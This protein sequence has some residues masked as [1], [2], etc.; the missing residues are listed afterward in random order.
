VG[1]GAMAY[2][3]K[4]ASAMFLEV[5]RANYILE[6]QV[7][8]ACAEQGG[9]WADAVQRYAN[10]AEAASALGDRFVARTTVAWNVAFP[11]ES[12]VLEK[13]IAEGRGQKRGSL[14]EGTMRAMLAEA[15]EKVGSKKEADRELRIAS[16]MLGYGE[17]VDAVRRFAEAVR[18]SNQ[19]LRALKESVGL[20]G[21][22]GEPRTGSRADA[23]ASVRDLRE[24]VN[25]VKQ[26]ER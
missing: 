20:S 13:V 5:A 18:V 23:S 1:A 11:L 2:A 3:S 14:Q 21:S 26:R 8:A 22:C 15:L 4:R 7:R 12:L 16:Q 9:N 25:E 17:N 6:Q 24:A 19:D 10:A